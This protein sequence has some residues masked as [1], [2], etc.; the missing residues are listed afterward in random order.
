MSLP[1]NHVSLPIPAILKLMHL[2]L[3]TNPDDW[4]KPKESAVFDGK[5]W[6]YS[7]NPENAGLDVPCPMSLT[8]QPGQRGV[9]IHLGVKAKPSKHF[10]I[11]PRSSISK[12]PLRMSNSV[13]IIDQTYRGE[14]IFCVDNVSAQPFNVLKGMRLCQ[15]IAPDL[16]PITFE[17]GM[18]RNDTTRG[19]GGFGSTG[20]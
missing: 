4:A 18:V 11:V 20:K 15:I 1:P 6:T 17:F 16:G 9:K 8:I 12:T 2:I 14:L 3:Q 10:M 19:E 7:V 5:K 13:G